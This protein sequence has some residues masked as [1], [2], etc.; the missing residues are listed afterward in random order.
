MLNKPTKY[1]LNMI[2][3][4]I[5]ATTSTNNKLQK[6]SK[7]NPLNKKLSYVKLSKYLKTALLGTLKAKSGVKINPNGIKPFQIALN[8]RI[9]IS[10]P[11]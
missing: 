10:P 5:I 1:I 9:I 3:F 7:Y 4:D 11:L 8:L 2:N 6:I